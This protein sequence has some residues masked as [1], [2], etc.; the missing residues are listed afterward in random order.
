MKR[1]DKGIYFKDDDDFTSWA[2]NSTPNIHIDEHN[3]AYF[4]YDFTDDYSKAVEDEIPLIMCDAGSKILKRKCVSIRGIS[5][6]VPDIQGEKEL[7]K[8]KRRV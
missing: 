5:L 8:N 3:V 1:T 6:N 4:D 7:T 2:V